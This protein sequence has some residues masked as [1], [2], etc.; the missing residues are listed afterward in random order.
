MKISTAY[1]CTYK[2]YEQI[3]SKNR[4]WEPSISCNIKEKHELISLSQIAITKLWCKHR[5]LSSSMTIYA[6]LSSSVAYVSPLSMSRT[7]GRRNTEQKLETCTQFF[8]SFQ[9][10]H[11]IL[12]TLIFPWEIFPINRSCDAVRRTVAKWT[13]TLNLEHLMPIILS[14]EKRSGLSHC[15]IGWL[16]CR[17]AK[18][19]LFSFLVL[20][21]DLVFVGQFVF[22]V[23]VAAATVSAHRQTWIHFQ[24]VLQIECAEWWPIKEDGSFSSGCAV[25][26]LVACASEEKRFMM[27]AFLSHC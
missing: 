19:F 15:R 22:V 20:L 11:K 5:R 8:I 3:A 6:R 13:G 25:A 18:P 17:L 1:A 23:F 9:V 14:T 4:K 26:P 16:H 21:L 24:W 7:T 10:L 27:C 2:K 12:S